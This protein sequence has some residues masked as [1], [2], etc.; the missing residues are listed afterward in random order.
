MLTNYKDWVISLI[1]KRNINYL[2]CIVENVADIEITI[3]NKSYINTSK[4]ANIKWFDDSL[5]YINFNLF[6][7]SKKCL[8]FYNLFHKY[9]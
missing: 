9:I 5:V 2:K 7:K 8:N 4:T 6:I 3:D 1:E